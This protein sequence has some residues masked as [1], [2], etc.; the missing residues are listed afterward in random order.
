MLGT[1]GERMALAAIPALTLLWASAPALAHPHIFVDAE[2]QISFDGDGKAKSLHNVWTF[3]ESYSAFAIQGLDADL[4]GKVTR[5]ELQ[6]LADENVSGLAEYGYYSSAG[7]GGQ[8]VAFVNGRNAALDYA[9]GR[10]TLSFD[11]DFAVP[12][13]VTETLELGI[14][15]PQYYVAI[16]FANRDTVGLLNAPDDCGVELERARP[17]PDDV[18]A[19]L[20]ALPADVTTLPATLQSALRGVQ[21]AI[22]INC[23]ATGATRTIAEATT[24]VDALDAFATAGEAPI[25][26]TPEPVQVAADDPIEQ[27]RLPL[28]LALL[29]AG[30][31]VAVALLLRYRPRHSAR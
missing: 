21:G 1:L 12:V 25:M 13:A 15:D 17:M 14:S 11:V 24:A 23:G 7:V 16:Q 3:D 9:D 29:A 4:D 2:A 30:A 22:L 27:W 20:Y 31:G 19:Q 6:S 18:A 10:A 28:L 8:S 5:A 26:L